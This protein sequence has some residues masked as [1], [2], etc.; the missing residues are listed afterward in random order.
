MFCNVLP[1]LPW[2]RP[3]VR[4]HH[5]CEKPADRRRIPALPLAPVPRGRRSKAATGSLFMPHTHPTW[6]SSN[7]TC[8]NRWLP[9]CT[10]TTT[11]CGSSTSPVTIRVSSAVHLHVSNKWSN[12]SETKCSSFVCL[13]LSSV[14]DAWLG[15]SR[16]HHS[17]G[18][19]RVSIPSVCTAFKLEALWH[20]LF[21]MF[22]LSSNWTVIHLTR[23]AHQ[24]SRL[25]NNFKRLS[26]TGRNLHSHV[27]EAPMTKKHYQV[28]GYGMVSTFTFLTALSILHM[29]VLLEVDIVWALWQC[30]NFHP[31]VV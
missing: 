14:W 24:E 4:L 21:A 18:T 10:R 3:G 26:R 25:Y 13:L 9:T 20:G 8:S 6:Y 5:H 12:V 27:H 7:W 2:C 16:W 19:Q 15:S 30:A 31:V 11:T 1:P 23:S 22:F 28:T 29:L 17:T